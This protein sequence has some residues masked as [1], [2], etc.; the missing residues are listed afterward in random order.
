[1]ITYAVKEIEAAS[2]RIRNF[3]DAVA[4]TGLRMRRVPLD[5]FLDRSES[6]GAHQ[7]GKH[8]LPQSSTPAAVAAQAGPAA[9]ASALDEPSG[10]L[11]T[12]AAAPHTPSAPVPTAIARIAVC[13]RSNPNI[14][15]FELSW[16]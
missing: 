10:H 7:N 14:G 12:A 3:A 4:D 6:G 15:R 5:E 13:V 16:A 8:R 1:M 2:W 9:P 11:A